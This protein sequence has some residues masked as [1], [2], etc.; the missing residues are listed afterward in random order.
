[1]QADL[2]AIE[3]VN[4]TIIDE[5]SKSSKM[6]KLG[7]TGRTEE[8]AKQE[9]PFKDKNMIKKFNQGDPTEP[10]EPRSILIEPSNKTHRSDLKVLVENPDLGSEQTSEQTRL[11]IPEQIRSKFV[12]PLS[13]QNENIKNRV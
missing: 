12:R 7:W 5:E 1:M 4:E 11:A 6:S 13:A 2:Y 9:S 10:T 3:E 8:A